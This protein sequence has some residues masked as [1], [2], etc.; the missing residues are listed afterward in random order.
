MLNVCF[1][2]EHWHSDCPKMLQFSLVLTICQLSNTVSSNNI[3][4]FTLLD[5]SLASSLS[6]KG[7][8]ARKFDPVVA[9]ES[10]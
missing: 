4:L 2:S 3:G 7:S 8:C 1:S 10:L 9:F 5:H 6:V